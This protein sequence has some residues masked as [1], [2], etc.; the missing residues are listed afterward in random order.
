MSGIRFEWD[1]AKNRANHRKHGLSFED[2][3]EV[4]R[5]PLFVSLKDRI[6]DGEQRWQTF[7]KVGS[8]LLVV[9]AHTVREEDWHGTTRE[10]IRIISARYASRKERQRYEHENG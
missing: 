4:F 2:A 5:D 10:V 1:E 3:S 7:G 8:S 6:Q 9:V